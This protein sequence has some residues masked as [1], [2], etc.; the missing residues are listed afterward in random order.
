MS[1]KPA[2]VEATADALLTALGPLLTAPTDSS[3][4]AIIPQL[5]SLN[6]SHH[7]LAST[8]Y[9]FSKLI[10]S[11][12]GADDLKK[13][14]QSALRSLV[15]NLVATSALPAGVLY[16]SIDAET[17]AIL[18]PSIN[19]AS[20]DRRM[21][22]RQWFTQARF[23]LFR[24]ES[25]GY[26]KVISLLWDC[27]SEPGEP[28]KV[29]EHCLS[30]IGQFSLDSNRVIELVLSAAAEAVQTEISKY[31]ATPMDHRLPPLFARLL[32][33]FAREHVCS[34][35]GAMMQAYHPSEIWKA[36]GKALD[37]PPSDMEQKTPNS[38]FGL[39][40]VMIREGRLQISDIW[41]HLSPKA[42]KVFVSRFKI[43]EEELGD[44]SKIVSTSRRPPP[45]DD[46]GKISRPGSGASDRD[47]FHQF[48]Y[49]PAGPLTQ[50]SSQKL[51]L[52]NLLI[53][54]C[55]WDDAMTGILSLS[56]DGE[57]VDIAAHPPISGSLVMFAEILLNPLL[58]SK[59]PLLYD[60]KSHLTE[61]IRRL[62]GRRNGCPVPIET[63]E[64]LLSGK[65]DGGGAVVRQMLQILGPHARSSPRLL[66]A[67]CRILKGRKEQEA[68]NIMRDVVLPAASL[69]QT[70][71]GLANAIWEVIQDWPHNVRWE[72]YGHLMH[73]VPRTCAAFKVVS[74]RASYEMRYI[75]KRLTNE[76]QRQHMVSIAK[77]THCQALSAFSAALDRV[78][79]YPADRV[80]ISPFIESCRW[81]TDLAIDMLLY[82]IVDR[83]ADNGRRRLKEDG[84]NTAQWYATLSLLL[85]LCLRKL[86]VKRQHIDGV[87]AFLFTKLVLD[88]EA[89][90]VFA[91]SDIIKCVADIDVDINMTDRQVSAHGGGPYLRAV[92][93]EIWGKIRLDPLKV[94]S[95]FDLKMERER[96]FAVSALQ[97]AF[98][99]TGAH[100]YIA[101]AI[102]QFTRS[103]V[104]HEEIRTMPLKLGA[105]IVDV[106]RTSLIQLSEFMDSLPFG[107]RSRSSVNARIW[108]PLRKIGISEM[109]QNL[110]VPSSSAFLLMSP[111]VDYLQEGKPPQKGK[112]NED[113]TKRNEGRSAKATSS[114]SGQKLHAANGKDAQSPNE[115][116]GNDTMDCSGLE[117]SSNVSSFSEIITSQ[118][119]GILSE[120]LVRAFWTLKLSDIAMPAGVY[121][122]ERKRIASIKA[123]WEKEMDQRRRHGHGDIDRTR[124]IDLEVR[125]IREFYEHL[126][127]EMKEM[128]KRE[129]TILDSLRS[130][131]EAL[132]SVFVTRFD[133][134]AVE[135]TYSFLQECVLPRCMVS[136]PDALFCVKFVQLLL[137]LDIPA[138]WFEGYFEKLL[139]LVP[140]IVRS[141]SENEALCLS[142]LLKEVLS[143]LEKWRSNRKVFETEAS[144]GKQNGFRD[145]KPE[146][147]EPM[148]HENFCQWLYDI[149]ENMADGLC[150]V[151]DGEEY[152]C[153]RNS[154]SILA[155]IHDVFPK[156]SEHSAKI[157]GHVG[158]LSSSDLADIRLSSTTVLAR[159][160][161]GKAKRL[162]QHIFKLKPAGSGSAP[163]TKP[164]TSPTVMEG[165]DRSTPD[166]T[167]GKETT[168]AKA[169]E[170]RNA[171]APVTQYASGLPNTS[172][173]KSEKSPLPSPG[174]TSVAPA[175]EETK[176]SPGATDVQKPNS[177]A[178]VSP[179]PRKD[180]LNPDAKEFVPHGLQPDDQE[181][182]S[183]GKRPRSA[184][185]SKLAGTANQG[186]Q[187][188][189]E[190]V[191]NSSPPLKKAKSE[192]SEDVDNGSVE[193]SHSKAPN[194]DVTG[195]KVK[196]EA[197]R[198][199][200]NECEHLHARPKQGSRERISRDD[201]QRSGPTRGNGNAEVLN[202]GSFG[203]E[204]RQHDTTRGTEHREKSLEQGQPKRAS[205]VKQ[206]GLP[207][208]EPM[209]DRVG[210][211]KRG[212]HADRDRGE[213]E[214]KK[215]PR[216]GRRS[217]STGRM[218]P[219]RPSPPNQGGRNGLDRRNGGNSRREPVR[220][221]GVKQE[222]LS[223]EGS[224]REGD[225]IRGSPGLSKRHS[226]SRE[227]LGRDGIREGMRREGSGRDLNTRGGPME[228]RRRRGE[229]GSGRGDGR[230][231][232]NGGDYGRGGDMRSGDRNNG[233]YTR[234]RDSFGR[235]ST[236]KRRREYNSE[237]RGMA[238][239][240]RHMPRPRI[241]TDFDR[242]DGGGGRGMG[243]DRR[244]PGMPPI[245]FERRYNGGGG[246]GDRSDRGEGYRQGNPPE[247]VDGRLGGGEGMRRPPR[248]DRDDVGWHP[249][250]PRD[251]GRMGN[252]DDY[253]RRDGFRER[254]DRMPA[255]GRRIP[256]RKGRRRGQR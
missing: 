41:H 7:V 59:F 234:D 255:D 48:K 33:E 180:L 245:P 96:K 235:G 102:A 129:A 115:I 204:L 163:A 89:L 80:T 53:P 246:R 24:E 113:N 209:R 141:C 181:T 137:D 86:Q 123:M 130:Q 95:S 127:L 122:A 158:K 212:E 191:S 133:E 83:M 197:V 85:G 192:G 119:N 107:V 114:M 168:D 240:G 17:H 79:G 10:T 44:I 214:M 84:I 153:T 185:G 31:A 171:K 92:V 247:W 16:E 183:T 186:T 81:C 97:S 232:G 22:T 112:G 229:E 218:S 248:D 152:L 110:H 131:K 125:R 148:R 170:S 188:K 230:M 238:D 253:E 90:L 14:R 187:P 91:L 56:V 177:T 162:P 54:M 139:K 134:K 34:V 15:E 88:E 159:L 69:L 206:E 251:E 252:R 19:H 222:A 164:K 43:Y 5:R 138:I 47:V 27:I 32:D 118:T 99:R 117:N 9:V 74:D 120:P 57:H 205:E 225:Q 25:E 161:A 49:V 219:L 20:E 126:E 52:I 241:E 61:P 156:V 65:E 39:V 213:R 151:L 157:E 210:E 73:E 68:V 104:Y 146:G 150:R 182:A 243:L 82:L 244:D 101:I 35:I 227:S 64:E 176:I 178:R 174:K 1:T 124:R 208:R 199:P 249:R 75:L 250:E 160:R 195:E 3:V 55:R 239:E 40:A 71:A 4:R 216:D 226:G 203:Q 58:R 66:H 221:T 165:V 175:N 166:Q 76:T 106:A 11:T 169:S 217:G 167:Q 67:L 8:I 155:G 2:D 233:E 196:S 77:I 111:I 207:R 46:N 242:R 142:V 143:I 63:V 109:I 45:G 223:R 190:P 26:A 254:R 228:S 28:V 121:E 231:E 128:T 193:S 98:E 103:A 172:A 94:G 201:S 224:N 13:N 50:L 147:S 42:N 144:S 108:E 145:R 29:V 154:L 179:A 6:P 62:G 21:R 12:P 184:D 194:N 38:L 116:D 132:R 78:Q 189:D 202:R 220:N 36:D 173:I 87:L 211:S 136:K 200:P 100:C 149:H 256:L 105:N 198:I 18:E 72:L 135:A 237:L 215:S 30:L 93:G 140:T 60:D 236:M 37:W 51:D 23:N 70:N